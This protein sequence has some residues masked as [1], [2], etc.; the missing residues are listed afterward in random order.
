MIQERRFTQRVHQR[1]KIDEADN[2]DEIYF[3]ESIELK[4][5]GREF[6]QV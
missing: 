3:V 5:V 2:G 1:G 6:L 4:E